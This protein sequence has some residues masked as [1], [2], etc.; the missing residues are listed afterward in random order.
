MIQALQDTLVGAIG[1]LEAHALCVRANNDHSLWIADRPTDMGDGIL[2]SDAACALSQRED[3]WVAVFPAAGSRTYEVPGTLPAC[4]SLILTVY[5]RHRTAG[6]TLNE[7]FRRTV[8]DPDNF[9]NG[10]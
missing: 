10:R 8:A 5:A 1:T 2:L 6:G 9:L 7:A 4:V 3:Q